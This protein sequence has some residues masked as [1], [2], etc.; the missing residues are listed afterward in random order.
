MV[1][2]ELQHTASYSCINPYFIIN[3]G[4]YGVKGVAGSDELIKNHH[5]TLNLKGKG[6]LDL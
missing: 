1:A 2:N 3:N 4:S 5:Q 6:I